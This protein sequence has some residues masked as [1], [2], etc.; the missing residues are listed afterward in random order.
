VYH[1]SIEVTPATEGVLLLGLTVSL[2][3]G[4]MTDSRVFSIPLIVER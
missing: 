3:Q 1:Q 4:D 2:K